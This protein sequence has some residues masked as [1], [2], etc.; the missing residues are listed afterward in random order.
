MV[1]RGQ[2]HMMIFSLS[3]QNS[4]KSFWKKHTIRPPRT[5][6]LYKL[7]KIYRLPQAQALVS[8]AQMGKCCCPCERLLPPGLLPS[9]ATASF[10]RVLETVHP[11]I[12]SLSLSLLVFFL[13]T[14]LLMGSNNFSDPCRNYKKDREIRYY[15]RV[16]FFRPKP[17][18]EYM[19]FFLVGRQNLAGFG[20]S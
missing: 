3:L 7:R 5:L 19:Y 18:R 8:E 15:F 12:A 11:E 14:T 9:P 2:S 17:Q 13:H 20:L 16:S 1:K 4:N 10:F 6:A